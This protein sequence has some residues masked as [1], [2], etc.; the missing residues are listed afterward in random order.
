[1]R[2]NAPELALDATVWVRKTLL[3]GFT[4][5]RDLGSSDFI[6][7]AL[8]NGVPDGS[9]VGPRMLVAV[10]GIGATGG[11]A[12]DL[13]G[14]RYKLFGRESGIEDGVDYNSHD[15]CDRIVPSC[16]CHHRHAGD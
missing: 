10:K 16:N 8:R 12:D 11:H 1:M 6:D 5:V 14:Y 4:T 13:S 3:A 9:I 15:K 7:V 2:K